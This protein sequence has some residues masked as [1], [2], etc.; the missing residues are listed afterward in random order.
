V[1]AVNRAGTANVTF[2]AAKHT[3]LRFTVR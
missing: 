1:R 3:L 2:S